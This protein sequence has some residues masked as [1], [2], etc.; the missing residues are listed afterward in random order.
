MIAAVVCSGWNCHEVSALHSTPIRSAPTK[1][2]HR[3]L[4]S[5]SGQAG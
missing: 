5:R 2:A 1:E 3:A 4:S